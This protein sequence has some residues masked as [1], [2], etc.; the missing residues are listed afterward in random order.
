VPIE[1]RG[2]FNQLEVGY[3]FPTKSYKLDAAAVSAY[4]KAVEDSNQLY[5]DIGFV[6]PLAVAALAMT[7]LSTNLSLP[8]G[9][10]HV[11]QEFEFRDGVSVEETLTSHARVVRN[12]SRG[13][14]HLF[15]VELNVLNKDQKT[16]LTGKTSFILPEQGG[17]A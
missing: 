11:S 1:D 2:D 6:P 16:V 3:E 17:A 7:V 9:A 15:D 8:P 5:S 14:M 10:I 12:K 13:K 4:L